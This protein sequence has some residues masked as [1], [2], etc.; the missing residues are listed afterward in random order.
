MITGIS[1][2]KYKKRKF[3]WL[4]HILRRNCIPKHPIKGKKKEE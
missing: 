2:R 4:G 3:N 1:Y